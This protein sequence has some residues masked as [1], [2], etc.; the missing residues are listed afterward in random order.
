MRKKTALDTDPVADRPDKNWMPTK[1][2]GR[3]EKPAKRGT[4]GIN[5]AKVNTTAPKSL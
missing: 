3:S 2:H 4:H 1:E 5:P